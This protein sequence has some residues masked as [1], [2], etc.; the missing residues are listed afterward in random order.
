M[1]SQHSGLRDR[2]DRF[3]R[4]LDIGSIVLSAV[5]T[6]LS[7]MKDE[8]WSLLRVTPTTGSFLAAMLAAGLLGL[9]IIQYRVLWKEKSEAHG[10]AAAILADLKAAGR[11]LDKNDE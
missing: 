11:L 9:S 5:L 10:R 4:W 1:L 3:G 7:L 8:Y 2:Y 6:A